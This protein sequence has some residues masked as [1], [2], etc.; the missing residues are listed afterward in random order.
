[1]DRSYQL[2]DENMNR[3][4]WEFEYTA[5]NLATASR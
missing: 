5:R 2:E 4:D 3:N 1:M